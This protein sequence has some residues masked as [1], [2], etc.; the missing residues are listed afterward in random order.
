MIIPEDQEQRNIIDKLAN[1]VARN[2]VK[3][4]QLTKE[5]QRDNPKF[6]FLYGG[7]HHAYYKWKV[8]I[9]EQQI[10]MQDAQQQQPQPQQNQQTVNVPQMPTKPAW[11]PVNQIQQQQQ[12]SE[13]MQPRAHIQA[14][15]QPPSDLNLSEFDGFLVKI[16]ES[17]TKDNIQNGKSWI[18][19]N[20]K[21]PHHC[22]HIADHL[23]TKASSGQLKFS[24][25][26]HIIYLVNDVGHHCSR[27]SLHDLQK[28]IGDVAGPLIGLAQHNES[29]ENKEKV[30]KVLK[31]WEANKIFADEI[32]E[33]LKDPEKAYQ[34]YE[35]KL[36]EEKQQQEQLIQEQ[37]IV[38][39]RN[40]EHISDVRPMEMQPRGGSQE[41]SGDQQNDT[42]QQKF[43]STGQSENFQPQM[44][45]SSMPQFHRAAAPFPPVRGPWQAPPADFNQPPPP[46]QDSR[47]PPPPGPPPGFQQ[48]DYGHQ[49][50]PPFPDG[51]N[52]SAP[53]TFDY[54]HGRAAPESRPP[55]PVPPP[56]ETRDP[57]IPLATYYDL[58]AGLMVPLVELW[59]CEYKQ[60]DP[61][62]LRLPLPQ[63]P[64]ERL[65]AAV[66]AYYS[67]P[68]HERPRDSTG[69]EKNALFE[70]FKAKLKY[71]K[72]KPRNIEAV[73]RSPSPVQVITVDTSR[74]IPIKK[75]GQ[76]QDHHE[77][78]DP[79]LDP[80]RRDEDRDLGAEE[81]R[82]REV[83]RLPEDDLVDQGKKGFNIHIQII[84]SKSR[85]PRSPSPVRFRGKSP[86]RSPTPPS[87]FVMFESKTTESKIEE[88]NVGHQ[89]LKKMGWSGKGLGRAGQGIEEPIKGGD[90]REKGDMFK[91]VGVDLHD[92]FE[93]YRRN[94][95]YT[96]NKP[97]RERDR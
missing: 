96:Y 7:E 81:N 15:P 42:R 57:T 28:A 93:T 19:N 21:S 94:K 73:E 97:R 50:R 89:L 23:L 46:F 1:F 83:D 66:E 11:Q 75:G 68:S 17:C 49:R 47:F 5:K 27:K 14:K 74:D 80:D 32:M 13:S 69:W 59:D 72:E 40:V 38:M 30:T 9:E 63:P 90:V 85:S 54:D 29:A 61:K 71:M 4:E 78:V 62:D 34:Q 95:S 67:H 64:S 2:G 39:Q 43:V 41:M 24:N 79:D 70:F 3:F 56:P 84:K 88:T 65:L 55:G 25:L 52:R 87:G 76:D 86:R 82:D 36:Q 31:I 8:H 51:G 92:P 33:I 18:I 22:K 37:K 77:P 53:Q 35:A 44:P 45:P 6:Q 60:L 20:A 91:G 10:Q 58:P 26:L 12:Q 48:F 16:M